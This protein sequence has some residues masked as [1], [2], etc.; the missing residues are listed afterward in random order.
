MSQENTPALPLVR[1]ITLY[2]DMMQIMVDRAITHVEQTH[3]TVALYRLDA[4]HED[5]LS[6]PEKHQL[7]LVYRQRVGKAYNL[8]RALNRQ[9]GHLL[10]ECLGV[11]E[12]R[13]NIKY[14]VEHKG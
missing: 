8:A 10:S 6:V 12:H 7:E 11:M 9:F 5:N 14:L 13:K 1:R 3:L 2:K 4:Q